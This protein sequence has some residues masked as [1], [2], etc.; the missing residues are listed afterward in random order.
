MKVVI[1]GAG[2]RG[3]RLAKHLVEENKDLGIAPIRRTIRVIEAEEEQA[4]AVPEL[5]NEEA[6]AEEEFTAAGEDAVVEESAVS[7]DGA[8]TEENAAA[9]E[10]AVIEED[11][12]TE[13]NAASVE[14]SAEED[15]PAEEAVDGEE[16]STEEAEQE[17]Q[18]QKE[19]GN[20]AQSQNDQSEDE[21]SVEEV[22]TTIYQ[23]VAD[24][25]TYE[26]ADYTVTAS[27]AEDAGIPEGASLVV[28]EIT[29]DDDSKAY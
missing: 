1:L 24:T 12:D 2:R 20:E 16:V 3:I 14:D 29:E 15:V 11:S 17:G 19:L 4:E 27:F 26:G 10:D 25:L 9:E 7:E 5:L 13:E 22:R 8:V 18:A 6:R 23:G 28:S 21:K